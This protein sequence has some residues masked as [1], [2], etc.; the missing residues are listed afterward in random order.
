MLCGFFRVLIVFLNL[1]HC[2]FFSYVLEKKS[3]IVV[4]FNQNIFFAEI[5]IERFRYFMKMDIEKNC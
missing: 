5:A 4:Y 2:L 1:V 3:K